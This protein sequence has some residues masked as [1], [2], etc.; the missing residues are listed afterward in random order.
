MA[1]H[2]DLLIVAI[3]RPQELP[4]EVKV[5]FERWLQHRNA[6]EGA[7]VLLQTSEESSPAISQTPY[8]YLLAQRANLDFISLS[9]TKLLSPGALPEYLKPTQPLAFDSPRN[10]EHYSRFGI[11]E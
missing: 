2:A 7:L 10:S 11:N 6:S 3:Q 8:L 4:L 1:A 9:D 5:W